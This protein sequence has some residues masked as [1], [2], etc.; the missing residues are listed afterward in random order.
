MAKFAVL[1]CAGY[2]FSGAKA[3]GIWDDVEEVF[4]QLAW[5]GPM[6]L[7]VGYGDSIMA[8]ITVGEFSSTKKIEP[9]FSASKWAAGALFYNLD[10]D[11]VLPLDTKV[12]DHLPFWTTSSDDARSQVTVRHLMDFTSGF[13][14][15][16]P[17]DG[18]E[19]SCWLDPAVT[20]YACAEILFSRGFDEQTFGMSVYNENHF[21]IAAAVALKA[22]GESS[23]GELWYQHIGRPAG[24]PPGTYWAHPSEEHPAPGTGMSITSDEYAK[25]MIA[26]HSSL[27]PQAATQPFQLPAGFADDFFYGNRDGVK[28]PSGGASTGG[29]GGYAYTSWRWANGLVESN[30]CIG[31]FPAIMPG[32]DGFWFSLAKDGGSM[33]CTGEH[34]THAVIKDLVE[35]AALKV[36]EFT[37]DPTAQPL[38][39]VLD[40]LVCEKKGAAK[41]LCDCKDF[42]YSFMVKEFD[43]ESC[44]EKACMHGTTL[45]EATCTAPSAMYWESEDFW[46]DY[47]THCI[48]PGNAICAGDGDGAGQDG[49]GCIR[50]PKEV[51]QK[52]GAKPC[53]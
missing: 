14:S 47:Y 19:V 8:N 6:N 35:Y 10:A 46:N 50:I 17:A 18:P 21:Q 43:G 25:F 45:S 23:F 11:G 37:S 53:S 40:N 33:F 44:L 38:D 26:W 24:L 30:S 34:G 31:Y 22:T 16:S 4:S 9:L 32:T 28:D 2:I 13:T 42:E 7:L 51:A 52:W 48:T 12:S 49:K 39:I 27:V 15:I 5:L 29:G 41:Y 20:H 3:A 1:G 36:Q